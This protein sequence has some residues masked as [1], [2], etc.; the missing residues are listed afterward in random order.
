VPP[1]L[2]SLSRTANGPFAFTL[3]GIPL[4]SYEIWASTNLTSWQVLTT[5]VNSNGNGVLYYSDP[6]A[7]NLTRRFYRSRLLNP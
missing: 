2:G 7:T 3:T 1:Q 6:G 5:L 4:R